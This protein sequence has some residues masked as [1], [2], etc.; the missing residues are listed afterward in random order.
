VG[1]PAVGEPALGEPAADLAAGPLALPEVESLVR[2]EAAGLPVLRQVRVADADGAVA[3]ATELG[4]PVVLKIDVVGLVHK[5]DAGAVRLGL[6]NGAAVRS[7]AAELLALP[8]P[9]GAVRRGLLVA[10]QLSGPELIVGGRRDPTFGPIVIVGLG[11]ILAD[12][13]DDVAIRLAPLDPG[14]AEAMLDDL[15]GA[16]IL[17]GARGRAAIDR[18]AVAQAIVRLGDLLVA[19][20]TILEIDCNPLI[21]GVDGTAAVDALVVLEGEP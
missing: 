9:A 3:A 5:S 21:S 12:V 6:T 20:P 2:L 8:L 13:L 1:E 16:A 4:F 19:D 17:A 18:S 14:T 7:A 10:R 15:R 11:G